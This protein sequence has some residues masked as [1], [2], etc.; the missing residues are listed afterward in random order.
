[1]PSYRAAGDRIRLRERYGTKHGSWIE[2]KSAHGSANGL[3]YYLLRYAIGPGPP[4][5]ESQ[6]S[7]SL[8]HST[9][10]D[11]LKQLWTW[12][13]NPQN[14]MGNDRKFC[15][16]VKDVLSTISHVIKLH[17]KFRSGLWESNRI[18]LCYTF[19]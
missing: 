3:R 13:Q 14:L 12:W 6:T 16:V 9:N 10:L 11:V 4:G 7:L 2:S 15:K 1:V 5:E 8:L 17:I 19:C 18:T